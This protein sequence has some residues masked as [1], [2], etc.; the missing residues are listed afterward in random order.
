MDR[1]AIILCLLLSANGCAFLANSSAE[2][3]GL[4]FFH[5]RRISEIQLKDEAIELNA[6]IALNADE[7]TRS[8]HFNVT[9]YN[10]KV[11]LT[12]EA[13]T[14][15]L[16]NK[17]VA[18]IRAIKHVKLIQ[19]E[20]LIAPPSSL[21]SRSN[22]ALITTMIKASLSEVR[23]IPGF[24]ATRVKVVTENSIVYLMG[25]VHRNEGNIAGE[26]ARREDGVK[27]VIKVFE[28]IE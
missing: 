5:D 12:G 17:I 13:P 26:I 6:S 21:T 20:M 9:A 19:N 16:R 22:D 27:R 23:N 1:I 8:C 14:P 7:T 15:E 4:S 2:I 11:L 24:D 25:L 10:G 3:S 18:I 28:Y